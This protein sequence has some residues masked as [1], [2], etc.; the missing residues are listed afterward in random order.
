MYKITES[1]NDNNTADGKVTRLT[2]GNTADII[3]TQ[4]YKLGRTSVRMFTLRRPFRGSRV[5][6]I[7]HVC[8]AGRD[9][10][11]V[12]RVTTLVV[13]RRILTRRT[14]LHISAVQYQSRVLF[15]AHIWARAA[16]ITVVCCAINEATAYNQTHAK[17]R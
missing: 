1:D 3:T 2:D 10:Q 16:H 12:R 6:V 9:L 17:C 8:S 13:T 4:R 14:I 7:T 15:I 5:I 11:Y